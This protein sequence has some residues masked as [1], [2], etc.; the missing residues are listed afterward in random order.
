MIDQSDFHKQIERITYFLLKLF[1]ESP[2]DW[3]FC[4]KSVGTDVYIFEKRNPEYRIRIKIHFVIDNRFSSNPPNYNFP[5]KINTV[6]EIISLFEE[7]N[8][9][10]LIILCYK[11]IEYPRM[12]YIDKYSNIPKDELKAV[13]RHGKRIDRIEVKTQKWYNK[14]MLTVGWKCSQLVRYILMIIDYEKNK[15]AAIT[16]SLD[17][18]QTRT[19]R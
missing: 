6:E 2:L 13:S 15:Q 5:P 14:K 1:E 8:V 10:F 16:G 3:M 18:S 9:Y 4:N 19:G 17:N 7:R 11:G 12:F